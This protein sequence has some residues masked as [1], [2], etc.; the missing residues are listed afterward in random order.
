MN[1]D[2]TKDTRKRWLNEDGLEFIEPNPLADDPEYSYGIIPQQPRPEDIVYRLDYDPQKRYLKVNTFVVCHFQL[3]S[4]A[5]IYF[6]ELFKSKGW[7]KRVT[8]KEPAKAGVLINNTKL[9]PSLRNA[10]FD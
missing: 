9:P 8:L 4:K 3:E 2:T 7:I 5:D 1:K 10:I 6:T